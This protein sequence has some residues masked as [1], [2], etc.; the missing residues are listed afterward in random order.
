MLRDRKLEILEIARQ[1]DCVLVED[2]CYGDVHYDG[3]KA[4]A[5]YALEA[6]SERQIYICSLSKI[7]A[8]GVRLGYVYAQPGML[9]RVLARR[10]DAGGNYFAAAVLAEYF[11]GSVWPHT[12]AANVSLKRKR[13]LVVS[14]LA[15]YAT[16]LCVW[17]H[18]PGG[19]FVWV[20][21]PD[22]VDNEKLLRLADERGVRYGVG[23]NFHFAARECS[24]LRLA[25]GHVPDADIG[26]GIERLAQC[27]RESRTSNEAVSLDLFEG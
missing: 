8:P 26:E 9:G 11:D 7:F 23:R 25:F 12:D 16:E 19:L 27:I 10:N 2:N 3:D 20:R 22:D 1:H 5:F 17:S 6:N 14:S 4:P 15:D 24:Y 13:D 21:Y 18:P